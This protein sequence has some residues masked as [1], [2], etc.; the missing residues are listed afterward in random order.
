MGR[1]KVEL[2][3]TKLDSY[4]SFKASKKACA[5]LLEVSED[6]IERRIKE[7]HDCTF[8]EYAE[9]CLIP[10]QLKLVNKIISK[11]LDGDNT[12]LIFALKNYCGWSDKQ[13]STVKT[14]SGKLEI[15]MPMPK[16]K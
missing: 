13:E 16:P 1:R 8:K 9:K 10:V 6:T 14:E 15:V 7:D 3:W 11:A 5:L 4:L 12:C 2:N